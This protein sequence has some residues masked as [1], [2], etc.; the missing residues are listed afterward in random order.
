MAVVEPADT[1]R[2]RNAYAADAKLAFS[3]RRNLLKIFVKNVDR[4]VRDRTA[5]GGQPLRVD[6]R[7]HASRGSDH[8]TFRRA[9]VVDQLERQTA[10]RITMQSVRA[11][12]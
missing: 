9:I 5:D 11:G 8:S 2:A 3:A 6:V 12:Q 1:D 7:P 10:G 4:G